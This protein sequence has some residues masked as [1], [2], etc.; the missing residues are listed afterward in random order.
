MER[1]GWTES[2]VIKKKKRRG[3]KGCCVQPPASGTHIRGDYYNSIY[4]MEQRLGGDGGMERKGVHD[5]GSR[6]IEI[7]QHK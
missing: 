6:G 2:G 3:K 4:L 7:M 1:P 5:G